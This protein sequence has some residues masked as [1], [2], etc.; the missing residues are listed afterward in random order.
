MPRR[1]AQEA[2]LRNVYRRANITPG[3]IQYVEAHGTGTPVGDPLE[4][5]AL[6]TVLAMGRPADE[7]CVIGSCKTNIGHLE[8]AAGVAGLIKVALSLKHQQI[9]PHLHFRTPNANIPFDQLCI[10]VPTTLEP[11][12]AC[13]GPRLAGVNSFGFGGTNA[14]VVVEEAPST[15][16]IN[17]DSDVVENHSVPVLLPLSARHP[18]ALRDLAQNYRER[19]ASTSEAEW[20]LRDVLYTASVRRS[21]HEYRLALAA[22]SR[23]HLIEQLDTF[24]SGSESV[25]IATG[26]PIPGNQPKL[27]FVF[28]GMGPQWWAMGREL[29]AQ[30]PVFRD[31]IEECD[32]L[33]Q[34]HAG[35][36][37]LNEWFKDEAESRMAET[38]IAQ[39]ANAMLQIAL[40]TLWQSWGITPDVVVGH[41]VGEVGAAYASGILDLNDAMCVACHRSRLQQRTAGTGTMMAVGLPVDQAKSFLNG[42]EDRISIGAINSPSAVT[43]SGDR[44]ALAELGHKLEAQQ[45]FNRFLKVNIPYHSYKLDP[46]KEELL[47][48]LRDLKPRQPTIPAY[49]TV[50]TL[51]CDEQTFATNYW[52][53]NARDPVRFAETMA[54]M[55]Q[56]GYTLFLEVGP[57]PVLATSIAE[58]LTQ[59]GQEGIVLPSLRRKDAERLTML[60]SMGALYSLGYPIDWRNLYPTGTTIRLP[61]YPWQRD[62]YWVEAET[63]HNTRLGNPD[64]HPLL[65]QRLAA[66]QTL[67]ENEINRHY[68]PYLNDHAIQGAVLYPG[69]GYVEMVLAAAQDA[70]DTT[71]CVLEDLEFRKAFFLH[72]HDA[73]KVQ[74]QINDDASFDIYSRSLGAQQ[75]WSLHAHGKLRQATDAGSIKRV[76]LTAL[77]ERCTDE[78]TAEECYRS[79]S[80]KGFQYGECFQGIAHLWR[81]RYD[82]V[83]QI[84]LPVA[85][86]DQFD[87]YQLHPSMLD[88]SFQALLMIDPFAQEDRTQREVFMPIGIDRIQVYGKVGP[89]VWSHAHI[90]EQNDRIICGNIQLFDAEGVLLVDIQGFRAQS[91]AKSR[92]LTGAQLDEWLYEMEWQRKERETVVDETEGQTESAC[93][94]IF[95]DSNGTGAA[96]AKQLEARGDTPILVSPSKA[97]YPNEGAAFEVRPACCE[98]IET[99]LETI[100]V[101]QEMPCKGILHLW[102]LDTPP[103]QTMSTAAL[104]DAQSMGVLTVLA[105]TQALA[106]FDTDAQ[107]WVVTRGAQPVADAAVLEVAQAPLWGLGRVIGHQEHVALWGGLI[108]LDPNESPDTVTQLVEEVLHS[109]S[110]DQIAFRDQERYVVRL[111]AGTGHTTTLP[112]QLR[113]DATYLITGGFGALGLLV[114][115]WLVTQGATRLI[116][117]AR[118]PL[119]ERST[120]ASIA[121]ADPRAERIVAV[122]ALEALGATVHLASV[123]VTDAAALT[124]FVQHYEAEGW[125]PIRGV[126]HAAGIVHDQLLTQM[127]VDTFNTVLRPKV[128]GGWALHQTFAEQPL[129]FF[130]LFSSVSSLVA[131]TGQGNYAAGNAFLDALS[132]TRRGLG[133]PALSINWGPWDV[134]MIADLNLVAHYER[135]GMKSIGETAG[136]HVLQRIFGYNRPHVSVLEADWPTVLEYYPRIPQQVAHLGM[137]EDTDVNTDTN[138]THETLTQQLVRAD[139]A[140]WPLIVQAHLLEMLAKVLHM[141]RTRLDPAVPL[142]AMGIDSLMATEFRN[143]VD[144]QCGISFS[145]VELLQGPTLTQLGARALE[146]LQ[147]RI[148]QEA[149]VTELLSKDTPLSAEVLQ[150]LAEGVDSEVVTQL[151]AEMENLSEED[152]EAL[153]AET[154]STV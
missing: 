75:T 25:G 95:T 64:N 52:W 103:V 102:G 20:R 99:L 23:E 109:D 80:E 137:Q 73:P 91:V 123:D 114:A 22:N 15:K 1:E 46:I 57:H 38:E 45:I 124:D 55:I 153:L 101:D 111:M 112:P 31:T 5:N 154:K 76:S 126:I 47:E 142:N 28:T 60:S 134:G 8:A 145:V 141:D 44:Q 92:N 120:W 43:L 138:T 100:L 117:L 48:S 150:E 35:W 96:L 130:I 104:T 36:S 79:L 94:I 140:E 69:A 128:L 42:Y 71:A 56:D 39:P 37:L 107:F 86:Q 122:R 113:A 146:Q 135:R 18:D 83:S 53:G 27:A 30:E 148:E 121:A 143:R 26:H 40:V 110:D 88:A 129:D 58:C 136:L 51:E 127:D 66:P 33:F 118:T 4:A 90:V 10:R 50:T 2:L 21:H 34:Q 32:R 72:D 77:R 119:P 16:K 152:V 147:P 98:D 97:A 41:S 14:H 62:R 9:P 132:H 144:L 125:P 13:D 12:P 87:L 149:R 65:G 24:V 81:G 85:L 29:F 17:N 106:Q 67:W 93:W 108:D 105:I 115:R 6:A 74:V 133:L 54:H 3:Q 89:S 59:E 84:E 70:Y 49:S 7:T 139:E 82:A 68:L 63:W 11:W 131:Q 116:L 61:A 78:C 19:L 151:L